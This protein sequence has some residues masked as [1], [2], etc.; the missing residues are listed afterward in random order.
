MQWACVIFSSVACPNLQYFST[1]SHTRRDFRKKKLFNGKCF[2]I[3]LQFLSETFLILRRIER[4][5][6]KLYICLHV[7]YPLFLSDFN[8]TSIFSKDFEKYSNIKFHENPCSG[9][10]AV[11]RDRTDGRLEG[12]TDMKRLI[13]LLAILRTRLKISL[14]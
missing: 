12:Q 4:N 5:T 13:S 11:P 3:F 1:F 6:I 7:K 14:Q 8:E 10:R 9:S 2:L